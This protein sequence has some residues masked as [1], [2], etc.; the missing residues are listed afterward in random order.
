[1]RDFYDK[2]SAYYK[3][4]VGLFDIIHSNSSIAEE[5]YRK[6]Y[7]NKEYR[8]VAITHADIKDNRRLRSFEEEHLNLIFIGNTTAYKGLPM[9]IETLQELSKEGYTNWN[10]NIW[11]AKGDS[12]LENIAYRGTFRQS[13]LGEVYSEDSLLIVPSIWSETFGFTSLEAISF[14][15][16]AMVS[17]TVGSK[18]IV[19][20]YDPWFVFEDKEGL[21]FK[22][23]ALLEDR[24]RLR[25]YNREIVA[26]DWKFDMEGHALE[27]EG[28]YNSQCTIHNAQ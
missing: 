2:L 18:N 20:E 23:K 8:K 25:G 6:H 9:L 1:M 24:T 4:M 27:M 13:E 17:A 16:P 26:Q 7:Q 15:I 28:V 14:G 19:E 12:S 22:L 10:L 5:E 3:E 11:G 21:R